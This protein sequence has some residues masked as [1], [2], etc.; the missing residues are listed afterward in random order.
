MYKTSLIV[1]FTAIT[2]AASAQTKVSID[3]VAKHIGEKV[4]VCSEVFGVK[5]LDKITFINVGAPHPKSPLTVI[6]F[7]K[8]LA[9]FKESPAALYNHKKICVV[10]KLE[11]YHGKPQIVVT[12]PDEITVQ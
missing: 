3:S 4:I 7:A 1:A 8:D 9:N 2:I 10:G 12:K 5:S 6:V 11:N